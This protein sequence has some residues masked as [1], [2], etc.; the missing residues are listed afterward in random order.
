MTTAAVTTNKVRLSGNCWPLCLP[1]GGVHGR[2][3]QN[4]PKASQAQFCSQ[5]LGR[6]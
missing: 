1:H 5:S 6:W 3:T 4:A 2:K